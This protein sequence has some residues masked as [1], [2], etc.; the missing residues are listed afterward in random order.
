MNVNLKNAAGF[1]KAY[2]LLKSKID[3]KFSIDIYHHDFSSEPLFSSEVDV[4]RIVWDLIEEHGLI[5][6]I[7]TSDSS[8][9]FSEKNW[10]V[11]VDIDETYITFGSK[12]DDET[13]CIIE[14]C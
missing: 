11:H 2:L 7:M 13:H 5:I 9:S 14:F 1:Q 12:N 4:E 6:T 10:L 3:W 8:Y